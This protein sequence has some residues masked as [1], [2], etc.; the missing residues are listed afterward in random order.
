MSFITD[1]RRETV[2]RVPLTVLVKHE[3]YFRIP[4]PLFVRHESQFRIPLSYKL[5]LRF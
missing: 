3:M 1:L 4:V 5:G 2:F